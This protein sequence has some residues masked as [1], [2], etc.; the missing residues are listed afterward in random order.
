MINLSS[1][2]YLPNYVK[3]WGL[4]G[5]G[6]FWQLHRRSER[7]QLLPVKVAGQTYWMRN[8]LSDRSIFFQTFVQREYDTRQWPLLHQR[9]DQFCSRILG[10][11]KTPIIIDAG[12]NIGLSARW[13]ASQYPH[14]RIYSIEPDEQNI[15]VLRRNA[16]GLPAI[17]I[18]AG[19]IWDCNTA[20]Q[21]RNPDAG[22]ASFRVAEGVGNIDSWT[23]P[24]IIQCANGELF[25]VKIDIEGCEEALFRSNTEWMSEA[26]LIIIELHDWLYPGEGT[27]RNFFKQIAHH[28]V[29][30]VFRGENM[31]CFKI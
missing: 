13:F 14:A 30:I 12:A 23:I 20:L 28:A 19:A 1:L 9:L 29:D 3:T 4:T 26:K 27:S 11:G 6:V 21:I 15:A 18:L 17:D 5:A 31:F 22:S 7:G 16:E 24:D 10:H 2:L 25:I 8:S